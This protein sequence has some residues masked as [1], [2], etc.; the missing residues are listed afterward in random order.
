[1]LVD[2]G[3][4]LLPIRDFFAIAMIDSLELRLRTLCYALP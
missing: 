1:V 2:F 3:A 4:G